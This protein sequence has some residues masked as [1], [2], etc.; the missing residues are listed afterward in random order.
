MRSSPFRP[1]LAGLALAGALAVAGFGAE[2]ARFGRDTGTAA[3]GLEREVRR[4]FTARAG[5][6]A[7]LTTSVAGLAARIDRAAQTHD[8]L[9]PL[10]LDLAR[11]AKDVSPSASLTV[12]VPAGPPGNYRVLAWSG[13][14]AEDADDLLQSGRLLGGSALFVAPTTLGLALVDLRP[15]DLNGHRIGV[16][17]ATTIL[18]PPVN[19]SGGARTF[20][21]E[22]PFGPVEL[23][24]ASTAA[25]AERAG[26]F[27]LS[28]PSGDPVAEA[29]YQSADVAGAR[30]L[31]RTRVLTV[32]AVPLV[33]LLLL[34]A[35]LVLDRRTAT[36]TA[37]AFW[38]WSSLTVAILGVATVSA[39]T[40][41]RAVDASS[42][43]RLVIGGL[44]AI[45]VTA[46]VP[47]SW[48]RRRHG[49][50][51]PHEAPIR[52]VGEHLAAGIVTAVLILAVARFLARTITASSL[53]EWQFPLFSTHADG[54]FYLAGLL[55]VEA[56]AYWAIATALASIAE[57]WR[58][59]WR[60]VASLLAVLCWLAPT[61][62]AIVAADHLGRDLPSTALGAAALTAALFALVG[63]TVRRRYRRTTQAMRLALLFFGLLWPA[64]VLYPTA[65]YDADRTA[66]ALVEREYAPATANHP[67]QLQDALKTSKD[68][69][70][71]FPEL[72]KLVNMQ[73][74]PGSAIDT[75]L[76]YSLWSATALAITRATSAIELYGPNRTLV[77]RFALNVPEYLAV[78]ATQK[79]SGRS[80]E[81]VVSFEAGSF[82]S[83]Q[84]LGL[85]AARGLCDPSGTP[86]GAVVVHV[87]P[88]YR[89][90]PFVSS[91]SPYY[92][93]LHNP[94]LAT[95]GAR[96]VDL[97]VVV[98][99]WGLTPAFTSGNVA[100]PITTGLFARLYKSR[101][102]FWT[103]LSAKNRDYR[104][105]LSDDQIGIYAL[106]YP[107]P[108]LL[109]H[110]TRLA[111]TA[112]V[113]GALFVALRLGAAGYA[114]FARRRQ[115]PLRVLFDEVRTSFYR[116][117]FLYF[118]LA[119][120]APV[121]V[122][123]LA[124]GGYMA[125]IFRADVESEAAGVV[126]VARRVLQESLSL[127]ERPGAAAT[128]LTD[129]VMVLIGQVINQDVNLFDG[130]Q[131]IAT[132]QRDLF[133]SGLLPTR[134]PAAAYLNI[135]L[136][137]LPTYVGED[138]L[139]D[140]QYLVA[141]A[142]VPERGAETVLSVPLAL[143]QREIE[144]EI[145]D[146]NRGVLAG[147]VFVVLLAAGFGVYIAGRIST[148]VARL[149]RAARQIAAGRLD[150]RIVADTADEL[151]R[152]VDDF[153]TM[154]AT[155]KAQRA[156]LARTN[157]LKAW[158]EMARQVA[159]EIKNPLTPI[160]LAAEHLQR[161]HVDRGRPLGPVF[162]QCVETILGQVRLL[163]TIAGEFSNFA[164]APTPHFEDASPALVLADVCE[165]YFAGPTRISVLAADDLPRVRVDRTLVARALTNV[166]ENALQAM[167]QG[168]T[169]RIEAH[170]DPDGFVRVT[171]A[172]TGV[173]L[174]GTALARVFE[175]YFSTKTGG[176][177]LGLPN[178]QRNIE[179]CGGTM[180]LTSA[181]GVGTTVT[182]RLPQAAGRSVPP[183]RG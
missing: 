140:F 21:L 113:A 61:V 114:R 120:V 173:G 84:R 130:S 19:G 157:Q 4:T 133:A 57:R 16:A 78:K 104:V 180:T 51:R 103:T 110:L 58:L 129:D 86:R 125:A 28:A 164:A 158:A 48:W 14:P 176:S 97:Q 156:E 100:W 139:G 124:F 38:V 88:D 145:D 143:R 136:E 47:I 41:A 56:A 175:P 71:G 20:L 8:A 167:P 109:E 138:R 25:G 122:L 154:A 64:V 18:S 45:A 159:H 165:P 2:S 101:D 106:G 10:F 68:D 131:L 75:R 1:F 111:E 92:D 66:Q 77:S 183:A 30:H 90:L 112:S 54:A 49:R 116:K 147:A 179:I 146:L 119:A 170:P 42:A 79:W 121:F 148:P 62:L 152:L 43:A 99:G 69:I 150:V 36:R 13:G 94:G 60:T 40:L 34:L 132:S 108:T 153:N 126:T 24:P 67:R 181:I 178:A 177:G 3:Q 5:Q 29:H 80:C 89:A 73:R 134:T 52:F 127:Q 95:R 23:A 59:G 53:A 166:I 39:V 63:S 81:W 98:Y 163:R 44:A 172:D 6:L 118:V 137:R 115:A 55:L 117:L 17:V 182:I 31:F 74:A 102:P 171:I 15:I 149:S 141:A 151:R 135:A 162:D 160:H 142:P 144:R 9:S 35:G 91:E 174:E 72:W 50:R 76:A 168:G 93:V 11:F 85:Q 26:T 161:V 37:A 12:Y 87:I 27:V 70:D 107:T 83:E 32:A 128:D 96:I 82:G 65:S 155:L 169:I 46:I 33:A 7:T 105:Y 22:T 123:A